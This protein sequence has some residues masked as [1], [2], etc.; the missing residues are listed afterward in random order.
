MWKTL[1][2]FS[3]K[4]HRRVAVVSAVFLLALT[5]TGIGLSI[6]K[7]LGVADNAREAREMVGSKYLLESSLSGFF[8]ELARAQAAVQARI[9]NA[10]LGRIQLELEGKQP[11]F[12]LYTLTGNDPDDMRQFVVNAETG[13]IEGKDVSEKSLWEKLHGGEIWGDYGVAFNLAVG[14]VFLFLILTGLAMYGQIASARKRAGGSKTRR[15][16]SAA[17]LAAEEGLSDRPV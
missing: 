8:P 6:Q 4:A 3:R 9:G 5:I 2:T 12:V 1:G 13:A 17:P 16:P 15:V 10:K 14:I 11:F 7:L